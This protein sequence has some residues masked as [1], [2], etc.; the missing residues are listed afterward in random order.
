M[1]YLSFASEKARFEE[2]YR[3]GRLGA[4]YECDLFLWTHTAGTGSCA[5]F[6]DLYI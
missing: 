3:T 5:S 4:S 6:G 1:S 2:E